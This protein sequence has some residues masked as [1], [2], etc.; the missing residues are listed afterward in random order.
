MVLYLDTKSEAGLGVCLPSA[1]AATIAKS[2]YPTLATWLVDL[3]GPLY[4]DDVLT[5]L[6][7]DLSQYVQNVL[8]TCALLFGM[9]V[10]Q[11]YYFTYKEQERVYYAL[12]AEVTEARSL[13]EQISLLS[14]GRVGSMYPVLLSRMDEYVRRD[15]GEL[16]VRD[17]IDVV[18]YAGRSGT[19]S[20]STSTSNDDPLESMMYATSVGVPG[21]M[22]DTVLSLR[23]ARSERCGAL[24]SKLPDVHVHVLRLL[25]VIVLTTFP[26]CGSGSSA[27]APNVL[28]LQS[29]MFGI[30]AFGL[31]VVL[32]V[33]EELRDSTRRSGG[34]YG[35]D[36]ALGV[37]VSG[38]VEELDE[39]M[40]GEYQPHPRRDSQL[41]WDSQVI[42]ARPVNVG[43][44]IPT[45]WWPFP[46]RGESGG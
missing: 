10:G 27:I 40:D 34:A 15:L 24:Q 5:V 39:R 11:A 7:N 13:L 19:S 8:T 44:L 30:L 31:T 33:V 35:V 6:S 2:V 22:Y 20:S 37:M 38:L 46:V 36:G 45:A 42:V 41:Q 26:V 9:L 29:Y 17:P 1:I 25:G 28:V 4:T 14:Y 43:L 12:F 21:P 32:G 16:S 23:R 3:P 18:A